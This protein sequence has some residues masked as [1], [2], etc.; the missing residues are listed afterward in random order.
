MLKC[1]GFISV[2]NQCL[3]QK[4]E[5]LKKRHLPRYTGKIIIYKTA[6]AFGILLPPYFE[7]NFHF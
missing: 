1:N 3:V 2:F 5:H 6:L 4:I 7:F